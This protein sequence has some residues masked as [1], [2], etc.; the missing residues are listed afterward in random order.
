MQRISTLRV[1]PLC[2]GGNVFGW[3]ADANTS[4]QILDAYCEGGGNFIDTAD[5]Y[6]TWVP[7]HR[8]GESESVIGGWLRS[9]GNR[10][11]VVIATKAAKHPIHRGLRPANLRICLD[12]SRRRLGVETIDLYYAHEDDLHVPTAEWMGAFDTMVKQGSI[13]HWG[14]SNFTPERVTE[15]LG[16][17]ASEGLTPPVALQPHYNL[18]HR[19]EVEDSGLREVV[20]EHKLALVPYYGLAAGFLTGKYTRDEVIHG[21]RA[22]RVKGFATERAFGALDAV[23]EVA[24]ELDVE[25]A[26][27]AL[28]WLRQQPGVTAPIASVSDPDQLPALL[29]S[30]TLKLS[31]AQANRLNK[32]SAGL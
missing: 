9:R 23:L 3:T 31:R 11:Q 29:A 18:V 15:V 7:G 32:A 13:R 20:A 2:L 10:D 17:A 19:A 21:Q 30:M 8:G 4:E 24:D 27:V 25:P 6:S 22:T 12:G 26:T 1:A 14:L 28:A 16:I 5:S